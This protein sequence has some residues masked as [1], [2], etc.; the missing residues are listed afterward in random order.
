[1]LASPFYHRLHI[2]QLQVLHR[3][4]GEDIFQQYAD[5]WETICEESK[6]AYS[7]TLLQE[8]IQT[9]LLLKFMIRELLKILYISQYFPPEMGA[10]AARAAELSRHWVEA[11]HEM[12]I[13]TGFPNH[14]T[15]KIP[16]EYKSKFRRLVAQG[17]ACWHQCHAY[18]AVPISQSKGI[19]ADFELRLVLPVFRDHRNI[20]RRVPT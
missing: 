15:G 5:K 11:G 4:T 16:L 13:L 8:R 3:I 18:L 10:P 1:M 14:P 19:R 6:Q 20:P 2:V 17:I 7:R 9:L 12:T